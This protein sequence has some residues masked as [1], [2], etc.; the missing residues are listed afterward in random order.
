MKILTQTEAKAVK[1]AI[2]AFEKIGTPVFSITIGEG[3]TLA[4]VDYFHG[5]IFVKSARFLKESHRNLLAFCWH[6]DLPVNGETT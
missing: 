5:S 2:E 4:T 6:Y 1:A 3:G